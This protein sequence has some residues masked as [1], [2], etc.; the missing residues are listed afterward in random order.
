V[1]KADQPAALASY[2]LAVHAAAVGML[3]LGSTT[4]GALGALGVLL[5]AILLTEHAFRTQ[6]NP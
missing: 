4:L 1:I 2:R 5:C 6:K 3:A